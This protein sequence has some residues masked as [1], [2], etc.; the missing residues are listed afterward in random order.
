MALSQAHRTPPPATPRPKK[1]LSTWQNETRPRTRISS[2]MRHW[3]LPVQVCGAA[4]VRRSGAIAP[5]PGRS[6]GRPPRS[7]RRAR[8]SGPR[9][10]G[11]APRPRG[12]PGEGGP[13]FGHSLH[14]NAGR[15]GQDGIDQIAGA[16][17]RADHCDRPAGN[18][19][20]LV[21]SDVAFGP[22]APPRSWRPGCDVLW[23]AGSPAWPGAAGRVPRCCRLATMS[24]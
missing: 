16:Q 6:C 17:Q 21:V 1:S 20:L 8:R 11:D 12:W 9:A 2:N 3:A 13:T 19:G 7:A 14:R 10:A 15:I 5:G 18:P 23:P 24:A 22:L 4:R